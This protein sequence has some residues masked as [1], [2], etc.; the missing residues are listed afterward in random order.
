[1]PL[2]LTTA[3]AS[4]A[5]I[6]KAPEPYPG[7]HAAIVRTYSP[8]LL[9]AVIDDLSRRNLRDYSNHA[10]RWTAER[11]SEARAERRRRKTQHLK[12]R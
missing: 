5:G 3:Q 7:S 4:A 1:M 9:D 8:G 6:L 2:R 10:T 11:L 12:R